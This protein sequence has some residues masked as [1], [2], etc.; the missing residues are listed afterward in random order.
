VPQVPRLPRKHTADLT[1][2]HA[3]HAKC[4]WMSPSATAATKKNRGVTGDQ[5]G[6]STSQEPAQCHKCHACRANARLISAS[7]TPAT[8]NASGCRQVPRLPVD[9]LYVDKLYVDK[10]CVDKLCVDKLC[11]SKLC[12]CG[13][14]VCDHVVCGQV[15]CV[16]HL[17]RCKTSI[18]FIYLVSRGVQS[19]VET[20]PNEAIHLCWK[21]SLINSVYLLFQFLFY[22]HSVF[23]HGNRLSLEPA[24]RFVFH[25]ISALLSQ[26]G[27]VYDQQ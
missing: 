9:K 1:K 16:S 11:V 22:F 6:P 21:Q 7:D 23:R 26:S 20:A 24:S 12:V 17:Y 2:C 14:V 15:V 25:F 18:P 8:P 13:Q 10:L 19:T 5:R 4:L 27:I 3:C